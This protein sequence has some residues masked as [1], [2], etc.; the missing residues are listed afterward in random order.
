MST[1]LILRLKE[2]IDKLTPNVLWKGETG[3][4]TTITLNE[5]ISNY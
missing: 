1:P 4:V 3:D 5:D 2:K